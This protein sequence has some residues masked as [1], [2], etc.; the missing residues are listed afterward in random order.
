MFEALRFAA[1][2]TL[3]LRCLFIW[4]FCAVLLTYA[5]PFG[6][7][8]EYPLWK[9]FPYW[10]LVAAISS[11]VG[12][13]ALSFCRSHIAPQKPFQIDIAS[14]ALMS[15]LFAPLLF[16]L[17]QGLLIQDLSRGPTISTFLSYAFPVAFA[18]YG[19]RRLLPGLERYGYIDISDPVPKDIARPRLIRRLPDGNNATVIRLSSD[20]HMVEVVTEAGTHRIRIRL[21][22]AV[23]EMDDV[24][25]VWTHRS[26][27][28]VRSAITGH[29][30]HSRKN[31]LMLSNGDRV[32]VSRKNLPELE[33]QGLLQTSS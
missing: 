18:V 8:R 13:F 15:V 10:L 21:A 27:W 25:G 9:M 3:T 7:H 12:N 33:A 11:F 16:G 6:T 4:I 19:V 1:K 31:F 17:T 32:P 24:I 30:R 2:N 5:G 20:D 29:E 28:V 14:A 26:H 23:S 22:D